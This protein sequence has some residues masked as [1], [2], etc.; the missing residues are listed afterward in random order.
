[1]RHWPA[2][3]CRPLFANTCNGLWGRFQLKFWKISRNESYPKIKTCLLKK[4]KKKRNGMDYLFIELFKQ[5][6][7]ILSLGEVWL[8]L[9]A[10]AQKMYWLSPSQNQTSRFTRCGSIKVGDDMCCIWFWEKHKILAYQSLWEVKKL[11]WFCF[12]KTY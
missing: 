11:V 7:K 9:R 6:Y 4:K 10:K 2:F 5:S 12:L 1:M 8:G 3:S